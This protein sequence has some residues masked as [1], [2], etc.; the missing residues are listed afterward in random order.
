MWTFGNSGVNYIANFERLTPIPGVTCG[1]LTYSGRIDLESHGKY[2]YR[3]L[4]S[5][6]GKSLKV[7]IPRPGKS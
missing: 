3:D 7:S 4:E 5:R 1:R 6:A 2:P